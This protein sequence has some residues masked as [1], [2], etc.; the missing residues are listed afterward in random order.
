MRLNHLK[1]IWSLLLFKEK[2]SFV[3]VIFLSLILPFVELFGIGSVFVFVD[4]ILNPTNIENSKIMS[5]LNEFLEIKDQKK[6]ITI[7][8]FLVIISLIIRNVFIAFNLWMVT[9]FSL[10]VSAGLSSRLLIS[11]LKFPYHFFMEN[12]HAVLLKNINTEAQLV[13]TGFLIP[14]LKILSGSFVFIVIF[15]SLLFYNFNST[16]IIFST[17]GIIYFVVYYLSKKVFTQYGK[18]RF[19]LNQKRFE[20]TSQLISGIQEIKVLGRENLFYK[21]CKKIFFKIAALAIKTSIVPRL[22]RLV[23]EILI[24]GGIVLLTLYKFSYDA[25]SI[26]QSTIS[27]IALFGM[28]SYRLMPYLDGL[29][30]ALTQIKLNS[31]VV[32]VMKKHLKDPEKNSLSPGKRNVIPLKKSVSLNGV[33]FKYRNRKKSSL[34]KL[35]LEIKYGKSVALV[36]PTGSGKS[37]IINL[38]LGLYLPDKGTLKVDQKKI[39][40]SNVRSWQKSIG[41]VPQEI[42]L[43]DEI[44]K[45]NI[46]FG[47]PDHEI[48]MERVIQTSKMAGIYD[49]ISNELPEKFNTLIGERGSRISGGQKQRIGIARALYHDPSFIVF[50]EATSSLDNITERLISET[51]FKT[52]KDKTIIMVAH[53]ISTI[54]NCD[55]IYVIN[56]G[57]VEA[58]GSYDQLL[59][60]SDLFKNIVLGKK[61]I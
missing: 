27:L 26:D 32:D 33:F 35:D 45:N 52:F 7:L 54:K 22:P 31:T 40:K 49:F 39:D 55:L 1:E 58:K 2:R 21:K 34:E 15:I 57:A 16:I 41:F 38:L 59:K 36:G 61:K 25:S 4:I 37:T 11:Y 6:L 9:S 56:K 51:V 30:L 14:L 42:Y 28:S 60:N 23:M 53:R 8:G 3:F 20:Y 12:N 50:D 44:V 47:I 10:N 19:E 29:F 48:D 13:A 43:S 24:F 46:A 18:E 17:L 5:K